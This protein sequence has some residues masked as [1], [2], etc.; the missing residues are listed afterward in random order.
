MNVRPLSL[1]LGGFVALA[2][3]MGI[4]GVGGLAKH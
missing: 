2:S 3:A 1:V 4:G